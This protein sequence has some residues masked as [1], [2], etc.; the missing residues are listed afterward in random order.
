M[1]VLFR[2]NAE[3]SLATL[4]RWEHL[5]EPMREHRFTPSR[6]WRFD[7][8]WPPSAT[9]PGVAVEVEGGS[10][11]SGAHT[12]G[13]HFEEDCEKYNRA[14]LDGWVLLRVTSAMIEDG[15]AIAAIREALA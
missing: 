4:I 10:W 9:G 14:A 1:K 15:R 12:R 6:R 5:P 11:I 3:E 8:A 2:S 13:A 7:F